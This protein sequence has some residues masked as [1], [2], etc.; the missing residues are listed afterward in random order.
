MNSTSSKL[1]LVIVCLF[2]LFY[3]WQSFVSLP[4]SVQAAPP[5]PTVTPRPTATSTVVVIDDPEDPD[6]PKPPVA[7][8]LLRVEP[9]PDGLWSVV[10]WQA[11]SGNWRDVEGWRGTVVNGKT[12]WWVEQKDFGKSP[13]RWVVYKEASSKPLATSEP[14]QLPGLDQRQ[15]VIT[16]SLSEQTDS[17]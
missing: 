6:A 13:F 17:K 16:L 9:A 5:R 4:A 1:I 8:L 12:I 11:P 2:V 7:T 10:Q 15:L 3:A 14:F